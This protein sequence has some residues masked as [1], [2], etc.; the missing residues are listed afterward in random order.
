V[1]RQRRVQIVQKYAHR[2]VE[3]DLLLAGVAGSRRKRLDGGED[4]LARW[5][6]RLDTAESEL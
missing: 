5:R 6:L 4:L 2:E 3:I 1:R